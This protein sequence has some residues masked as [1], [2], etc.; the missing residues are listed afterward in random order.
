MNIDFRSL[1]PLLQVFDMP[2]SLKFYRDV[3]GFEVDDDSGEGDQSDWISLLRKGVYLMLNAAFES[4]QRPDRPDTS[5]WKGHA[6]VGLFF[7]CKDLDGLYEQLKAQ[8]VRLA[9]PVIRDYGMRQLYVQDPD[10]YTLCFQCPDEPA[11]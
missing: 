1:V 5:R 8:N 4:D 3:L 9:P 6:D 7:F 10:G 11:E 2:Q